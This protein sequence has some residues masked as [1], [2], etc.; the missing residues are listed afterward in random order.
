[1]GCAVAAT[2]AVGFDLECAL[3]GAPRDPSDWVAREAVL[4]A[5]GAALDAAARVAPAGAAAT[6]D[7]RHWWLLAP[8]APA[9]CVARIAVAVPATVELVPPEAFAENSWLDERLPAGRH[10]P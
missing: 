3:P 8:D 10:A 6:L 2:G 4:K 7:G 1:M 5:A 9:G